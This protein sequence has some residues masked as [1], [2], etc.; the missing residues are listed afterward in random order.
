MK[1]KLLTRTL[2]VFALILSMLV[3]AIP[4]DTVQ[5]ANV[6]NK[7]VRKVLKKNIKNK[8]CKYAFSDLDKDGFDELVVIKYDGPFEEDI[9]YYNMSVLIYKY[10]GGKST[11][12]YSFENKMYDACDT[13]LNLYYE[14]TCYLNLNMHTEGYGEDYWYYKYSDGDFKELCNINICE[15]EETKYYL[16]EEVATTKKKV[17]RILKEFP[18]EDSKLEIKLK[19]SNKKLAKKFNEEYLTAIIPE[20]S[21]DKE[22]VVSEIKDIDGNGYVDLVLKDASGERR[23]YSID[24]ETNGLRV[25]EFVDNVTDDSEEVREYVKENYPELI[26]LA[27]EGAISFSAEYERDTI[28]LGSWD[29]EYIEKKGEGE[30]AKNVIVT[31]GVKEDIEWDVL[32]YSEDGQYAYAI[33]KHILFD[34]KFNDIRGKVDFNVSSLCKYLNSD[35]YENAFSESEKELIADSSADDQN[36]KVIILNTNELR[37]YYN[38]SYPIRA[39]ERIGTYINGIAGEWWTRTNGRPYNDDYE[40]YGASKASLKRTVLWNG[41]IDATNN[42]ANEYDNAGLSVASSCG[43]RPYITIR[44]T[45]EL[46]EANNLTA[47]KVNSNLKKVF[48]VLGTHK[49]SE[50]T[51]V[52]MEWEIL[53][54]DKESG[55]M[56]CVSRYIE[57]KIAY[58]QKENNSEISWKD[59]TLRNWLNS[60]FY[61]NA[62]NKKEKALI[63]VATYSDEED[64]EDKVFI[65]SETEVEKYYPITDTDSKLDRICALRDGGSR[66]WW[67]RTPDEERGIPSSKVALID[68]LGDIV[69]LNADTANWGSYAEGHYYNDYDISV[70]DNTVRPAIY[71]KLK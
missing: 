52:P 10:S 16:P 12:I 68:G 34:R 40:S 64:I 22:S 20:L 65:L 44:L 66:K 50:S 9:V 49:I 19:L 33:S 28:K 37:K 24:F 57:N 41:S 17:N 69:V 5:A 58:D 45:P 13:Y 30:D 71:I 7:K 29:M 35:F 21:K 55:K 11:L 8:F 63:D 39:K 38:Y 25:L 47:G 32:G 4:K 56:L 53:D 42:P 26:E 2:L 1:K 31:D 23:I 59:C 3:C 62:F 36:F 48:V 60:D 67:L 43:V 46:I 15:G 54:Y 18:K 70:Y 51:S 61:E 14:D 6:T 27:D